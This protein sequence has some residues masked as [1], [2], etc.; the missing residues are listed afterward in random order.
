VLGQF[1]VAVLVGM[2][3]GMYASHVFANRGASTKERRDVE[4]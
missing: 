3:V 2:F 4:R 1:F